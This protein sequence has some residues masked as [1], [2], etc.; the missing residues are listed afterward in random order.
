MAAMTRSPDGTLVFGVFADA[1]YARK[2]YADRHC[3]DSID[4]LSAAVDRF[5]E[6]GSDF[7]VDLGDSIDHE[8]DPETEIRQLVEVNEVLSRV[9][10]PAYFVLGNHD[11]ATLTKETFL[12][13]AGSEIRE[14]YYSF[15]RGGRHFVV[16]DANCNPDG[17]AYGAGNFSWDRCIIPQEQLA[18][19]EADLSAAGTVPCY[20]FIHENLD[21]REWEGALDPHC[22]MNHREVREVL[23]E[24]GK[25]MVVFQGHYHHGRYESRNGIH[26]VTLAAMVVGPGT[27][28]NAFAVVRL[29]PDGRIDVEGAGRQESYSFTP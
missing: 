5:G 25:V 3:E 16:L 1:H 24:S 21:D 11:L 27:G 29:H 13:E 19:L 2:V 9:S 26:Y 17:S 10:V 8:P 22:V 20:V 18:W 6:T 14:P 15:D 28:S 23:E 12:R 4:K 7:I